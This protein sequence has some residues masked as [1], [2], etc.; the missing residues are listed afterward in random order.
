MLL[1]PLLSSFTATCDQHINFLVN[2]YCRRSIMGNFHF[3]SVKIVEKERKLHVLLVKRQFFKISYR[4]YIYLETIHGDGSSLRK[5]YINYI[6][7]Q[8]E[9][10]HLKLSM[11]LICSASYSMHNI[12]DQSD[13]RR[14]T[15]A[16][17]HLLGPSK[18]V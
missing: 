10:L 16:L 1:W 8:L 13:L 3:I 6:H 2:H 11:L 12:G 14:G 15:S 4:G 9:T 5:L 18:R 17:A 7:G